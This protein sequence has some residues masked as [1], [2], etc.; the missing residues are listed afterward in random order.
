MT[1]RNLQNSRQA[2]IYHN[3]AVGSYQSMCR[4]RPVSTVRS[5]SYRDC[6]RVASRAS[7]ANRIQHGS[8]VGSTS[9]YRLIPVSSPL[10]GFFDR[11]LSPQPRHEADAHRLLPSRCLTVD[12]DGRR[13]VFKRVGPPCPARA[14]ALSLMPAA[15]SPVAEPANQC[16]RSV[17]DSRPPSSYRPG[18]TCTRPSVGLVTAS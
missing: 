2:A 6:W 12:R 16:A 4:Y 15:G 1:L 7:L 13:V 9:T 11:K 5:L 3:R 17:L 10:S 14:V 18:L 8:W